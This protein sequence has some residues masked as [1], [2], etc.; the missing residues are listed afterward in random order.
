MS[1]VIGSTS[2]TYCSSN[3]CPAA[4]APGSGSPIPAEIETSET[5]R[6]TK[7]Q[8]RARSSSGKQTKAKAPSSKKKTTKRAQASVYYGFDRKEASKAKRRQALSG[9]SEQEAAQ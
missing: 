3:A 5:G 2:P 8:R 9:V 7:K 4:S 1:Y 6:P